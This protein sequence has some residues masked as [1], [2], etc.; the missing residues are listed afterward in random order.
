MIIMGRYHFQ[1]VES[2]VCLEAMVNSDGGV[3]M[4]IKARPGAANRCY[5]GLMKHR[6]SKLLSRKVKCLIYRPLIRPVLTYG[7][8]TWAVGKEGGNLRS[9]DR[10]VLRIIFGPVLEN[11]CWRRRK[12]SAIYKLYDEHDVEFIKLSRLRWAGHVMRMDESGPARKVL[13]TKP[14]GIGD[15][16]NGRPK[17]RW[18]DE[19]DEYVV[20]FRCRNWRLNA[21]SREEWRKLTE[22]KSHPAT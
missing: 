6:S 22:V 16:K 17:L 5:F 13:C 20:R 2:F 10:K 7:S 4:E 8:E 1:K 11:G 15:S 14:G 3:V 19:L 21:L 18:C 12:N 9:F